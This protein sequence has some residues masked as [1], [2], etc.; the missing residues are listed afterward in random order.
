[1]EDL[2]LRKIA[3]LMRQLKSKISHLESSLQKAPS[4]FMHLNSIFNSNKPTVFTKK[5]QKYNFKKSQINI[6]P[7]EHGIVPSPARRC[8]SN[9]V[10]HM[11]EMTARLWISERDDQSCTPKVMSLFDLSSLA[12]GRLLD[13]N[14]IYEF[15]PPHSTKL[16]LYQNLIQS[17]LN[18]IALPSFFPGVIDVCIA[19]KANMQVT[20]NI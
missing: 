5:Y 9:I 19:Y 14:E 16:V 17:C 1:M 3:S 20:Y 15:L 10:D 18:N 6:G 7:Q 12:V 4:S 8:I 13:D 2:D 11:E